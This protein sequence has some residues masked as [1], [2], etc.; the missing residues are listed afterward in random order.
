MV[1]LRLFQQHEAVE[2]L[3]QPARLSF[4]T[5][6]RLISSL[7]ASQSKSGAGSSQEAAERG[8]LLTGEQDRDGSSEVVDRTDYKDNCCGPVFEQ[9]FSRRV[10]E[11]DEFYASV[12][13]DKL[14]PEARHV[15][16]Q[17]SAMLLGII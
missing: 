3:A 8:E 15:Q 11:A 2:S 1:R 7:V 17:V 10:A 12:I 9:V 5:A 16:R 14:S 13:S 4:R 6:A